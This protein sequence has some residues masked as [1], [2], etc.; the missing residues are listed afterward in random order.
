ML[1]PVTYHFLAVTGMIPAFYQVEIYITGGLIS[2]EKSQ[3]QP[4]AS[5]E[6]IVRSGKLPLKTVSGNIYIIQNLHMLSV[7]YSVLI[8]YVQKLFS[9]ALLIPWGSG[10]E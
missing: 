7:Q 8:H 6:I 10:L 1:L 9:K 2:S 4:S 3:Y 5:S